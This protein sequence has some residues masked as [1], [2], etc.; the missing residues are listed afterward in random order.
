[1]GYRSEK[2]KYFP[3]REYMQK[4]VENNWIDVVY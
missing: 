3:I 4:K 2:E 1:M